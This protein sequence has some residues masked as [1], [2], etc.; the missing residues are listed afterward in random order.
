MSKTI[1]LL[2]AQ[3]ANGAATSGVLDIADLPTASLQVIFT[4]ANVVGTLTLQG[5]TDQTN[6]ALLPGTTIAVT[7]SVGHIYDITPTGVQYFRV[8]WAYTSGAGN[9]SVTGKIKELLRA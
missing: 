3:N 6:W 4:G 1:T 9:I 8:V 2:A 5:S 7:A